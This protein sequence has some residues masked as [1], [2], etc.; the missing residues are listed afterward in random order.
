[1]YDLR[2]PELLRGPNDS[3][4]PDTFQGILASITSRPTYLPEWPDGQRAMPNEILRSALFNCRNRNIARV[5]MKEVEI[6]VIGDGEVIYRGEEL[7][8]DDELVWMHLMHLIKKRPLGECVEFTPYSF[9]KALGWPIKGQNYERL[10]TCLSRMQATALRIQSRRLH[11]FISVS[12]IQ[13]FFSRNDR[14][15]NLPRWQ[16]WVGKEMQLLFDDEFLT[17]VTWETRRSLPDGIA[18]KLFGYWASHRKPYPVKVET[19]LRLCGSGMQAK[20]FRAEL[21]KALERLREVGF[22]EA[23]ELQNELVVVIRRY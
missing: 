9:I 17:R 10:R 8:Q 7:R 16:V 11:C 19:L 1:M 15:E 2:Q 23:W 4:A 13:K 21:K 12:L 6:A 22:L 20:H 3:C 14:N 18:S 5:F